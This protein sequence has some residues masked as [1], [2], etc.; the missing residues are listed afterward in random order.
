MTAIAKFP[1]SK[2]VRRPDSIMMQNSLAYR[3]ALA[4]LQKAVEWGNESWAMQAQEKL[5]IAASA[6]RDGVVCALEHK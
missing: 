6:F 4:E 5:D 2:I 1:A 3:K